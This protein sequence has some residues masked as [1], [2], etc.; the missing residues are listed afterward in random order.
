L[1][2]KQFVLFNS[3]RHV[4]AAAPV[5]PQVLLSQL[6][7]PGRLFI[8]VGKQGEDQ[9]IIIYDKDEHGNVTENKWLG[10]KYVPLTDVKNQKKIY[11]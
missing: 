6:K 4:G 2:R 8:P 5:T 3:F 10:V 1:Y 11:G 7:S 9:W